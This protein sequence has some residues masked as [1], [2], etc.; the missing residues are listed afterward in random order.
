MKCRLFGLWKMG[1]DRMWLGE[2][3]MGRNDIDIIGFNRI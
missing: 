3:W 2:C 1:E